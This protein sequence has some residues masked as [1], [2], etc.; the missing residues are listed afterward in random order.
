MPVVDFLY[1][2]Y[3]LLIYP[4][5]LS[6]QYIGHIEHSVTIIQQTIMAKQA[7]IYWSESKNA[8]L[9]RRYGIGFEDVLIALADQKLLD[10]VKHP[11]EEKYGHQ[12]ILIVEIENYAYCVPYVW[13]EQGIFFKTLFP[14]RKQTRKYLKEKD[15]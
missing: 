9:L 6:F 11:N 1:I 13:D 14:S 3:I 12:R 7:L 15:Q 8:E 4:E 10:D 2:Q 5:R